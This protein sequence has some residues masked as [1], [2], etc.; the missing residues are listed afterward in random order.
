MKNI[1][2]T[3]ALLLIQNFGFAQKNFIDQNYITVFGKAEMEITPDEIY[4][5]FLINEDDKKG[6]VSVEKQEAKLFN[7]LKKINIDI[8]KS[9]KVQRFN[10]DY[11]KF[12]LKK[13]DVIK[14]KKYE[15]MVHSTTE[16]E[17]IFKILEKL[18]IS[19]AYIS[20][21]AHSEIEKYRKEVKINAIKAAKSKAEYLTS[22][23]GQ[24]IGNA[25]HIQ[26]MNNEIS[27]AL[28]GQV[29]GLL[30]NT[31]ARGYK[32]ESLIE[33]PEFSNII[34]KETMQV[35]FTIK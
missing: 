17:K 16:L 7:E 22:S 27:S 9:L 20:K 14:T 26:E 8:N 1:I 18:E 32:A 13:D 29:H 24:S 15:L 3:T 4:I 12:L 2:I 31:Y 25:I 10:S 21:I 35:N 11:Q 28:D 5:T 19:N 6:K 33:K 34:I 30:S 23:I